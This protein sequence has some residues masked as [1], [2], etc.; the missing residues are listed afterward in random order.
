MMAT[1]MTLA[2]KGRA[3][4]RKPSRQHAWFIVADGRAYT[5]TNTILTL[6]VLVE[7]KPRGHEMPTIKNPD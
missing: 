1:R 3:I 5:Y 2:K 6:F 4:F 7:I